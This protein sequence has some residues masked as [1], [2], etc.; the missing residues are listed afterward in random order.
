MSNNTLAVTQLDFDGIRSNLVTF[1]QGQPQFKDY[2]FEGSNLSTLLDL[3]S[4]NTYI[5][6]FYT[7]M[8]INE[9]FL[10][11]AVIRDS[12][13]SHA[14]ELNYL[15]RSY[16]SSEGK[17]DITIY[18]NDNPAYIVI[19]A[20]TK[21]NS[22]DGQ[23][24][25]GFV[26][27]ENIIVT[28]VNNVY[29][30][31]KV[32]IYEGVNV[33]EIFNVNNS[34]ENQRFILSNPNI[35][36]SSLKVQVANSAGNY[37]T[38]NYSTTLLGL[39]TDSKSY[40]LQATGNKYEIVFGENVVSAAPPNG[41][42][43]LATYRICNGDAPNGI[44]KY[45]ASGNIGGYGNFVITTS[46][47]SNG[48][49]IAASSGANP[50]SSQSIRVSA[51]RAYQ[52]L[53]RAITSNDY[54]T[55]VLANFPEVR[56]LHVYGGD[57]LEPPQYGKVYIVVDVK[58]AIGLSD[59]EALKI[60]SFLTTKT[61][62][63]ITPVVVAPDYTFARVITDVKYNLNVSSLSASDIQSLIINQIQTYNEVNLIDFN[64][65]LRY[66]KLAAAIDGA[67]P[68]ITQTNT[69]LQIFKNINPV[70]GTLFNA[71]LEYQNALVAGTI[72]STGFTFG[73]ATS[74]SF[75]DDGLGN[76]QIVN[77]ING[78]KKILSSYVGTIDYTTGTINIV[79]LNVSEY[80]GTHISIFADTVTTDFSCSKNTIL[81]I[82]YNQVTINVTGI[83][84]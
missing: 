13:I 32:S 2:D 76:L 17:I 50:E 78:V 7:N 54:K 14:K 71:A 28:P 83:R 1:L 44:K 5:N 31:S 69:K 36:T 27:T 65:T 9:M 49:I 67:D 64:K 35:D 61:P 8:A 56:T 57:E 75:A 48:S 84:V 81:E 19:P 70:S 11:T 3:L 20:G 73:T 10:D 82:D 24:V 62:I 4:Y 80:F 72:S 74:C 38:W 21:F 41:S 40:F 68:S 53:D 58:N 18:P 23:S 39:K 59:I 6:S 45:K 16:R 33:S 77:Y 43:V 12:V 55:I 46:T 51:P 30:V 42:T 26:T 22:T 66:S 29:S 15:P 63:S 47:S 34:I 60:Q 79:N 37:E 52:T 25:Y